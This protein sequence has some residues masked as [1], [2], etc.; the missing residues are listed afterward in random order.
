VVN[1]KK[2]T[3]LPATRNESTRRIQAA[4]TRMPATVGVIAKNA[5]KL[6]PESMTE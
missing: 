2:A 5:R 1:E 6:V 4:N 3:S